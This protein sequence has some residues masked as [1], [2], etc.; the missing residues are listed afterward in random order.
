MVMC[1]P[2]SQLLSDKVLRSPLHSMDTLGL[3]HSARIR[4]Q[5]KKKKKHLDVIYMF[6]ASDSKVLKPHRDDSPVARIFRTR[7]TLM[8]DSVGKIIATRSVRGNV[9]GHIQ[10]YFHCFGCTH[11]ACTILQPEAMTIQH[12]KQFCH[13]GKKPK[14]SDATNAQTSILKPINFLGI[15]GIQLSTCF[16]HYHHGLT[17]M[18]GWMFLYQPTNNQAELSL[19]KGQQLFCSQ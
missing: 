17:D 9:Y 14:A 19:T 5:I 8:A 2:T 15:I 16:L 1:P 11:Y 3:S 4:T 6:Q 10:F 7:Q 13:C 18:M 12:Y